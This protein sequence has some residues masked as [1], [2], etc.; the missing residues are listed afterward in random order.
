MCLICNIHISYKANHC[1]NCTNKNKINNNIMKKNRPSLEQL[2]NDFSILK[3]Y[4]KVGEKYNV[5]DNAIRKWIKSY[6]KIQ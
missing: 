2:K 3:S 4:V 1:N 6:N 5:S